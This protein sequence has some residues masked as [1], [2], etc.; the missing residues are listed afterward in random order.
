MRPPMEKCS[1]FVAWIGGL[2]EAEKS[3]AGAK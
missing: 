2:L 3:V 1:A